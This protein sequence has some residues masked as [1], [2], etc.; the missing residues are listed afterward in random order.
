MIKLYTNKSLLIP[1]NRT[2]VH[3]L[4]F[5]L[6][7]FENTHKSVGAHYQLVD[8]PDKAEAFIFPI[9]YLTISQ[10]G[11]QEQFNSLYTL[12]KSVNK[13]MMIYVGGDYG[14]TFNDPNMITWRNAG[15]KSA[16]DDLTII[17]PAFMN[18]PL[19][20]DGIELV[21]HPYQNQPQ[22]SF[23][24][25]AISSFKEQIRIKLSTLKA[26]FNRKSGK[27]KSD[28]QMTY[29]AAGKR[30]NNLKNLQNHAT[31]KTDFI[32]RDKYR[33]GAVTQEEREKSTKEF[34]QN[35]NNSPYTFCLR[36]AGNFSVR[37]YEALACGRIPVLIDT[38]VHLPLENQINWDHHICRVFTN[39]NLAEKLINF[40]RSHTTNSFKELQKS[41][42]SLYETHLVRHSYFCKLH[43]TLKSML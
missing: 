11:Y 12:A 20:R 8:Q 6:C 39:E 13:K 35:L 16:N 33:A 10:K 36:G 40:H 1:E 2:E 22:I 23:T 31:I 32:F 5:D 42:R 7:Y 34:F 43:N 28:C 19:D 26:N 27:D 38:D 14:K 30:F 3:P 37:F 9:N 25:F 24:G 15:F 17:L 21:I 4:L 29:N 41:N 18:D